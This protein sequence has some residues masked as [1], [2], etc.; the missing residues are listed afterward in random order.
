MV[1]YY[2]K[3]KNTGIERMEAKVFKSALNFYGKL[4]KI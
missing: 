3:K 2:L 4:G 1:L